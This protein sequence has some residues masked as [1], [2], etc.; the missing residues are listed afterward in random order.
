MGNDDPNLAELL[1]DILE[2]STTLSRARGLAYYREGRVRIVG[3]TELAIAALVRGTELYAVEADATDAEAHCTCAAYERAYECKHL[4]AT[5]YAALDDD[6]RSRAA[7]A[8]ACAALEA[9]FGTT[10]WG[11]PGTAA[12]APPAE[13][14]FVTAFR[15]EK[16]KTVH[17]RLSLFTGEEIY[18]A[19]SVGTTLELWWLDVRMHQSFAQAAIERAF[20][21][22]RPRIEASLQALRDYEPPGPGTLPPRADALQRH[23]AALYTLLRNLLRGS[24]LGMPLPLAKDDDAHGYEWRFAVDP[25]F[26]RLNV[27]F[28]EARRQADAQAH[29]SINPTNLDD[30]DALVDK[31][32]SDLPFTLFALRAVLEEFAS[33]ASPLRAAVVAY[34]ATDPWERALGALGRPEKRA[35]AQVET[36]W[37]VTFDRGHL[38]EVQPLTRTLRSGREPSAW[39]RRATEHLL[40]ERQEG[41]PLDLD[42]AR[43]ASV[44]GWRGS[45]YLALSS[46]AA[47]AL[48]S[49]LAEHPRVVLDDAGQEPLELRVGTMTLAFEPDAA[50]VLMPELYVGDFRL[51]AELLDSPSLRSISPHVAFASPSRLVV[52]FLPRALREWLPA[53]FGAKLR[54]SFPQESFPRLRAALGPLCEAGAATMPGAILGERVPFAP[55]PGA[56]VDWF[57]ERV[58]VEVLIE[59]APGAP[60]VR[61]ATG[62]VLFPFT[63]AGVIVHV[64]RDFDAEIEVFE[65]ARSEL[66]PIIRL[67]ANQGATRAPELRFALVT[68]LRERAAT[69]RVEVRSG[70]EPRPIDLDEALSALV[71]KH[72]NGW[73]RLRAAAGAPVALGDLFQALRTASRYV[74]IDDATFMEVPDLVR[75]KLLPLAL[76]ATE[77]DGPKGRARGGK[78]AGPV[79]A[80]GELHVHEGF[81]PALLDVR[82]LFSDTGAASVDW[83]VHEAR[84]KAKRAGRAGRR[85]SAND[86]GVERGTLRDYQK[87][88]IRWMAGLAEWAPGCVLADDMGLGKTVQT[89]ALLLARKDR[90]PALVI[91]PASVTFNWK[92]ELARFVPSLRVVHYNLERD[93]D[94]D[95]LGPGDVLVVSYGLLAK[96]A[97]DDAHGAFGPHF[98][99]VVVDEAQY[100]KNH[101]TKRADAVRRVARDFTIALS[102]TPLENHLG[103]LWSVFSIV[104]PGLLGDPQTFFERFRKPIEE[105]KDAAALA[106]LGS[107]IAPFILRRT[108]GQVLQELPPRQDIVE[109]I[110]LEPK[111]K[112]RY[113]ALR[114]A[115]ELQFEERDARL[116]AA[117]QRI[118]LFAALTRLRQLACDAGLVDKT[119]KGTSSKLARLVE[120]LWTLREEGA[121]TLVFSQFTTL[122]EKAHDLLSDAGHRVA[123][124]DGATP[125]AARKKLVEQFQAG[126]FDVFC[127]SLKAGGTGLNLTRASY[128]VHLDPWWNPAVEEQA[129]SRAH[130]MGQENPVT[131]YRLVA[132]GTI[133]EAILSMHDRKRELVSSVLDGKD[134]ASVMKPEELLAFIRAR[135]GA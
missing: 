118:Q 89:A 122:L 39:K 55:R 25:R 70:K 50:G 10:R 100:L 132:R 117:Q 13:P 119:F 26:G 134:G 133:E 48:L 35:T 116:T 129:N 68:F 121:K 85:T 125:L 80:T 97:E 42:I 99:T 12:V 69:W 123:Y 102:G 44:G 56:S 103:E 81:A 113:E 60:L 5:A 6:P 67:N 120:L 1:E 17:A 9:R 23:L 16:A 101:A 58:D 109:T 7:A 36:A 40:T 112:S 111:E 72:E 75:R 19:A 106:A 108:R 45:L 65:A 92:V 52:A 84:F 59:V 3:R 88:G 33:E 51:P 90:G 20:D 64:E 87:E 22:A 71:V 126:E 96:D 93:V 95:A 38:L 63:R 34:L 128:V 78:N 27:A 76:V 114:K 24:S 98:A 15:H 43:L 14:W 127:I 53:L 2:S 77:G 115:C 73:F 54:P 130:R 4:A 82:S 66:E 131:T 28:R 18:P 104:F 21:G 41:S 32:P 79:D 135:A 30:L 110:E 62:D 29:F 86:L 37:H 46:P 57:P 94:V 49:K 83:S 105:K 8:D 61:A 74:A 91:A 31:R 107:L 124:L 11:G 47:F